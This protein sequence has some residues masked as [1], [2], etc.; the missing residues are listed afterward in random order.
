MK[1]AKKM[2]VIF[3]DKIFDLSMVRTIVGILADE[4]DST[5]TVLLR[6]GKCM[7]ITKESLLEVKEWKWDDVV[8]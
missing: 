7:I 6:N 2:V 3:Q 8:F 4:T 1:S 5:L